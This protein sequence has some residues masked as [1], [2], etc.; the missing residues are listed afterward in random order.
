MTS[1]T[2]NRFSALLPGGASLRSASSSSLSTSSYVVPTATANSGSG[3]VT[4][5]AAALLGSN[6]ARRTTT[7]YDRNVIKSRGSEVSLGAWAFLFSEIVQYT[8]R[9]VSGIGEFEKRSVWVLSRSSK[10]SPF[11]VQVD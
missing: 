3:S 6:G 8:Q 5:G 10:C 7:I 11:L 2:T 4:T 9:R 1:P